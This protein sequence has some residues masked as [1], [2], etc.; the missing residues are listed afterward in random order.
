MQM[1]PAAVLRLV[2][3]CVL[4]T[5]LGFVYW[6]GGQSSRTDLAEYKTKVAV[7]TAKVANLATVASELARKAE[8]GKAAEIAGIAEQYEQDKVDAKADSDRAVADLRNGNTR[9]RQLWQAERATDSLSDAATATRH[10]DEITRLREEAVGRIRG[11]GAE[12]DAQIRGL[13]EVVK[14]DRQ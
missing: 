10:A 4:L 8:Q 3:A 13:Q 14:A 5:V 7:N 11:I 12:A 2:Q 6:L 9:L 1:S